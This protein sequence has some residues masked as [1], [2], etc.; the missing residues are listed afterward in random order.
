MSSQ[1]AAFVLN[2]KKRDSFVY[3][4]IST[5]AYF[6]VRSIVRV[7]SSLVG[8]PRPIANFVAGVTATLFSESAKVEGRRRDLKFMKSL[9][10]TSM[11]PFDSSDRPGDLIVDRRFFLREDIRR[12]GNNIF[13][14]LL[15]IFLN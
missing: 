1:A 3:E 13:W 2:D 12:K 9:E 7:A 15:D 14:L 6:G 5:G 4:E 10:N 11:R 8:I